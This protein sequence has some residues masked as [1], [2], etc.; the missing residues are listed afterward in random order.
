MLRSWLNL[1]FSDTLLLLRSEHLLAFS[2]ASPASSWCYAL[3][4]LS[5]GT[6]NTLLVCFIF[7]HF[8]FA[9]SWDVPA[10]SWRYARGFSWSMARY[11]LLLF[12]T[13]WIKTRSWCYVLGSDSDTLL[14][15]RAEPR[16]GTVQEWDAVDA[17]V[18]H[19][20]DDTLLYFFLEL[21][22]RSCWCY[23]P[24]LDAAAWRKSR[25]SCYALSFVL[26]HARTL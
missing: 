5:M 21:P 9:L 13:H 11:F 25:S 6:S 18:H 7:Q 15:L 8:L 14:M 19:N 3:S 17:T 16:L 24:P 10:R 4:C 2:W 12:V 22:T 23:A 26:E 20:R 1:G